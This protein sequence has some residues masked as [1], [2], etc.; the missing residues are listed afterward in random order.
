MKGEEMAKKPDKDLFD[1]LRKGGVRKKVAKAASDSAAMA[2]NGKAA[3][4][5]TRTVESLKQAASEPP[6]NF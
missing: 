2:K 4:S 1:S 5:V 3:K 6:A